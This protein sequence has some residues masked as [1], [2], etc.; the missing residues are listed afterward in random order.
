[1]DE[2]ICGFDALYQSHLKSQQDVIWKDSVAHYSLH[3]LEN[4]LKLSNEL[5]DGRYKARPPITFTITKPKQRDILA[6]AYRDRVY[7]RS[8]NDLVLY[9]TMVKSFI[10]ENGACQIGKGI[11]YEREIFKS[12]LRK[13]YINYGLDGYILQIDIKKYYQSMKHSEVLK[14]FEKKLDSVHYEM[15][16]DVLD[17]QYKGDV[18]YRAG[19][20]MVQIAGISFLNGVDH[21]SKEKLH[22]KYYVRYMD[23]I[24]IVHHDK[25]YLEYCKEEISKEL[26]MIGLSMHEKKTKITELKDGITFLGF[27]WR[28]TDTGKVLQLIKSQTIKDL[29]H[30]INKLLKLC[31]DGKRTVQ[32]VENSYQTRRSYIAK[33]NSY[34]LL[35]RLDKWY[36][37]R[38]RYYGIKT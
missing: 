28:I 7:Q 1:M 38:K 23:D 34:K 4:T 27:V 25:E 24:V 26:N 17:N 6:V 33:G 37:E 15:V 19:S 5:R 30:S 21:F 9:P 3:A 35:Q 14:C 20:Q 10:K 12:Y 32:C 31:S 13:Y 36:E 29:K 2:L 8:I 18:G 16:R 22:L 11:D